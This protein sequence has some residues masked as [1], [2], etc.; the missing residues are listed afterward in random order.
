MTAE[1]KT[2]KIQVEIDQFLF[3]RKSKV[4]LFI[5]SLVEPLLSDGQIFAKASETCKVKLKMDNIDLSKILSYRFIRQAKAARGKVLVHCKMGISRS[6]SV[7]ISYMMKE[8]EM[9][10]AATIIR[11]KEKR[12]VVNPNKS[13]IKQLEVRPFKTS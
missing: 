5:G 6:A 3:Y 8:Y 2:S 13:F 1:R 9:D 4:G 12:S 7:V 10:L 11:V